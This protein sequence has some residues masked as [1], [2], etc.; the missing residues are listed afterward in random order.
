MRS[1]SEFSA[2]IFDFDYTLGDATKGIVM[3]VNDALQKMSMPQCSSDEIRK[4][5]GLTLAETFYKLTGIEEPARG[6][7]FALRFKEKADQVMTESTELFPDTIETLTKLKSRNAG[8]GIVTTK[9]HYWIDEILRKFRIEQLIDV[10]VGFEDVK[11]AKPNEEGLLSAIGWMNV[12]KDNAVYIGD[13]IVDAKTARNA[14]VAFIAVTTGV[15]PAYA[16]EEFPHEH[17]IYSLSELL[18][19]E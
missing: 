9:Y 15:T 16:F 13:S 12:A 7:E 5:V 8:L 11:I 1:I 10:I 14:G 6:E 18:G 17:I 3:C 2:Y 4:T 19:L